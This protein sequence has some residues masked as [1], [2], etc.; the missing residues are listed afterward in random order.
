MRPLNAAE[1]IREYLG[2]YNIQM[3]K[4]PAPKKP[5]SVSYGEI[6]RA[7]FASQRVKAA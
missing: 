5:K 7:H 1:K 3:H 6:L 4:V 2:C